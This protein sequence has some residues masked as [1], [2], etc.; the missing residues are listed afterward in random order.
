MYIIII[1]RKV[2]RSGF[3]PGSVYFTSRS[4]GRGGGGGGGG[5]GRGGGGNGAGLHTAIHFLSFNCPDQMGCRLY[6]NVLVLYVYIYT[7][8]IE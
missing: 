5:M 2:S 3:K 1:K 7:V 8:I 4:R 6:L